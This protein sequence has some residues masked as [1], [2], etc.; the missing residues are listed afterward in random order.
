MK[1][2]LFA[3]HFFRGEL[4]YEPGELTDLGRT[5]AETETHRATIC[6]GVYVFETQKGWLNMH[7][8]RALLV[9]LKKEY[10]EL[11]F[12]GTL[13]GFFSPSVAEKLQALGDSNGEGI[14]LLN[15]HPE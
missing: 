1:Y 4:Q 8:L 15:L 12:E 3:F 7:R 9:Q 5:L 13:A 14:S 6:E 10:V 2:T 11:P